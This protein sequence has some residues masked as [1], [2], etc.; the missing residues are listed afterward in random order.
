LTN[1]TDGTY[2]A[3][4]SYLANSPLISQITFR[5]SGSTKVTTT[6][7]YDYLNRLLSISSS[8]SSSLPISYAYG[9]NDANQRARVALNDG[10]FWIY[11]Y[12]ALGQVSAGKKYFSDNTPVPAQQFE[13]G[14]DDI[15]NRTS[16]KAGGD[17]SGAGLPP[18][19]Y[20]ANSLN[21]YTN[22]TV[23]SAFDV[24]GIA[25]A[26][27]SVTVNSSAADYRRGEYFQELVR[28]ERRCKGRSQPA[29]WRRC[30]ASL[31]ERLIGHTR[32]SNRR[33][34]HW[35]FRRWSR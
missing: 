5:Q 18:A 25:N 11:Q 15:G 6:K 28:A 31:Q 1:V 2:S 12:D 26:S 35:K 16:T 30:I 17:Q 23:P 10:S 9:Y 3:G 8:P 7:Q 20:T 19:S 32:N 34:R 29:S 21:Q 14:L 24:I 33:A 27:S 13:Y 22:R 4:Y